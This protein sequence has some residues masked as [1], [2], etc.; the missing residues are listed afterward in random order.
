[1]TL[2]AHRNLEDEDVTSETVIGYSSSAGACKSPCCS[3]TR[4]KTHTAHWL[5]VDGDPLLAGGRVAGDADPHAYA[6]VAFDAPHLVRAHAELP[7]S[8]LRR[9]KVPR[10][11]RQSDIISATKYSYLPMHL[12]HLI[13]IILGAVTAQVDIQSQIRQIGLSLSI[14][15]LQ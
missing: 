9:H 2:A 10:L 12:N 3:F 4:K 7:Q 8:S 15:W 13:I 11:C 1:M 6:A 14:S 5:S